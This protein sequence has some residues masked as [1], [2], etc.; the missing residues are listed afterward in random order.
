MPNEK[1]WNKSVGLLHVIV[2]KKDMGQDKRETSDTLK[3]NPS[4]SLRDFKSDI[5]FGIFL[6]E[7][8]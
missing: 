3:H 7:N 4:T 5:Q 2:E 6:M 8:L 1:N